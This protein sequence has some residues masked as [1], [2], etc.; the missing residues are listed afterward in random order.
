MPPLQ[1]DE[2]P[3]SVTR[4]GEIKIEETTIQEEDVEPKPEEEHSQE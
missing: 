3:P 2:M 4:D 1:S